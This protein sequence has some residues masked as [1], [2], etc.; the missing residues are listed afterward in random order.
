M[1]SYHVHASQMTWPNSE[2]PQMLLTVIPRMFWLGQCMWLPCACMCVK[3]LQ[4]CPTLCDPMDYSPAGSFVHGTLQARIL[5]WVAVSYSK[6][7]YQSRDWIHVS[8]ISCIGIQVLYLEYYLGSMVTALYQ[9][10]ILGGHIKRELVLCEGGNCCLRRGWLKNR[11]SQFHKSRLQNTQV[12][13]YWLV[14]SYSSN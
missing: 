12:M 7:S 6:G 8:N 14:A 1:C 5:E 10:F 3:L 11:I 4:S 9:T 2:T 13:T